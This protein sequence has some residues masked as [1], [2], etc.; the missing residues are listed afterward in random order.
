MLY[1]EG[2]RTD[3]SPHRYSEPLSRFLDRSGRAAY[4]QVRRVM[5]DWF[6]H[7]CREERAGLHAAI[8]RGEDKAFLAAYWELYLH[9]SLRRAFAHVDC[10]PSLPDTGRRPDF[11]AVGDASSMFVEARLAWETGR[12][13]L[14]T[15]RLGR[16]YDAINGISC[17]NFILDVDVDD[18]GPREPNG[19][20]LR[21]HLRRWLATLDVDTEL[22]RAQVREDPASTTWTDD[23]WSLSVEAFPLQPEH[24][25]LPDHRPLGSSSTA[26]GQID[27]VTPIRK[28]LRD[29]S[30]AYGAIKEPFIIA[31]RTD[32][33]SDMS[34][35]ANAL[36]GT[37]VVRYTQ[38]LGSNN[39]VW[40]ERQ[41]D[42]F[43]NAGRNAHV[44]GVLVCEELFPWNM[45]TV[46]PRLWLNPAADRPC[47]A[48]PLWERATLR[49]GRVVRDPAAATGPAYFGLAAGWPGDW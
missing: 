4:D 45:T 25:N 8:S 43:W 36:F 9:E 23:G 5:N 13:T 41:Q 37:H 31:L 10:H 2:R 18:E 12:Q 47:A 16:L 22:R 42:G 35:T 21:S 48:L 15:A 38:S 46:T 27:G 28:S 40:W 24:R 30:K 6:G 34:A 29:K 3:Q 17:P 1:D 19:R 7:Y 49:D 39:R 11:R 32:W 33:R 14:G 20:Y 44:S 26:V